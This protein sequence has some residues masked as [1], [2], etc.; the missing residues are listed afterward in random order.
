MKDFHIR[1]F[2]GSTPLSGGNHAYEAKEQTDCL[3]SKNFERI[4]E[5]TSY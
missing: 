4:E 1:D 5:I 3:S 2:V